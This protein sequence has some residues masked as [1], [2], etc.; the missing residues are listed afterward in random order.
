MKK[1]LT[2]VF[3]A[4]ILVYSCLC[5]C[6]SEA[7]DNTSKETTATTISASESNV[8]S[9][10]QSEL[11]TGSSKKDET[12]KETT[13]KTATELKKTT[14][15]KKKTKKT[16]SQKTADDKVYSGY[17]KMVNT[18]KSRVPGAISICYFV[19]DYDRDGL[20]ELIIH[21]LTG[22]RLGEIETYE[23][24]KRSGEPVLEAKGL[25][26]SG[27]DYSKKLNSLMSSSVNNV[28]PLEKYPS[29]ACLIILKLTVK[30]GEITYKS[31]GDIEMNNPSEY[32]EYSSDIHID[33][34]DKGVTPSA[35][36]ANALHNRKV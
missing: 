32:A 30:N 2:A 36:K 9:L 22:A 27:I 15:E 33:P 13:S 7:D 12:V 10:E 23:Y 11:S 34:L 19:Y 28:A 8:S 1:K 18:A 4:V 26:G 24:D 6:S 29:G 17:A 20:E 31:V 3:T 35:V 5:S 14:A 21:Y 25:C 16:T